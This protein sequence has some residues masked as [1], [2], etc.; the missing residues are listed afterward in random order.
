MQQTDGPP[1]FSP[2]PQLFLQTK[3][4]SVRLSPVKHIK[5]LPQ[6]DNSPTANTTPACY[7]VSLAQRSRVSA[8][9]RYAESTRRETLLVAHSH[10]DT[11][12]PPVPFSHSPLRHC[13]HMSM[14]T[15]RRPHVGIHTSAWPRRR[16][17]LHPCLTATS[18]AARS[19]PSP[20][21][22]LATVQRCLP[23]RELAA[24]PSF[25]MQC[26]TALLALRYKFS[27]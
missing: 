5:A 16:M 7:V 8:D 1:T 26:R 9:I 11:L 14:S 3:A 21:F 19:M 22:G 27:L 4:F 24:S 25:R 18:H 12:S 15:R 23:P 20:L 10:P 6:A 17:P 2:H 13:I